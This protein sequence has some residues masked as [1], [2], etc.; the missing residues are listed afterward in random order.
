MHCMHDDWPVELVNV[1]ALHDRHAVD[2]LAPINVEYVPAIQLVH[3]ADCIADHVP[4]LQWTHTAD[5]LPPRAAE[6]EPAAH[7]VHA[8]DD[9]APGV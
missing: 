6:N 2:V 5:E 4:T 3:V 1:P 9:T 8:L 7:A